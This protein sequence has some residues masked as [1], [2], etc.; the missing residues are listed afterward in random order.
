MLTMRASLLDFAKFQ[1]FLP[2]EILIDWLTRRRVGQSLIQVV[3]KE[4]SKILGWV[5]ASL[6]NET[7]LH[8]EYLGVT[9]S[10]LLMNHAFLKFLITKTI[11][12]TEEDY[13]IKLTSVMVVNSQ[14]TGTTLEALGFN[15]LVTT[16]VMGLNDN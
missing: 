16:Y 12:F 2:E 6:Q 8:I 7:I 13:R 15:P 4:K 3:T 10:E 9:D 14:H 11:A 5:L 1:E